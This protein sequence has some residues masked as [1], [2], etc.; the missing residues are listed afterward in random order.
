MDR[1]DELNTQLATTEL[2]EGQDLRGRLLACGLAL[3]GLS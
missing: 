1:Y 3:Q 2:S